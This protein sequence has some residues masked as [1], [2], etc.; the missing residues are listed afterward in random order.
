MSC[1][2]INV[3]ASWLYF[4]QRLRLPRQLCKPINNLEWD[5][6]CLKQE[7]HIVIFMVSNMVQ[8]TSTGQ[9]AKYMLLIKQS[10]LIMKWIHHAVKTHHC[11]YEFQNMLEGD[12]ISAG[13]DRFMA[14]GVDAC[15][16]A[17]DL[18]SGT[19]W[20]DGESY[21]VCKW[22][23]LWKK[24]KK[25]QKTLSSTM[26]WHATSMSN[27]QFFFFFFYNTND[28]TIKKTSVLNNN[29]FVLEAG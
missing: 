6:S 7:I 2:N 10:V 12:K 5:T 24:C 28:K 13:P 15:W 29:I 22:S 21:T 3:T 4:Y 25:K 8:K 14:Q 20:Y 19:F 23:T 11:E 26:S 1:W 9:L 18:R 27:L 16:V 17:R